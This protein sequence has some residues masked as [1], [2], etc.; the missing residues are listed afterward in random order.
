VTDAEPLSQQLRATT[1][2][3]HRDAERTPFMRVFFRAEL[4]RDA[5][6][7][8]L[9]RQ[10]FIYSA[11]EEEGEALRDDPVVG[12]MYAPE[13]LRGERLESDL[14][15]FSGATW[16]EQ[17]ES[18]PVTTRYMERIRQVAT[19]WPVGWVAHQWLRYMGNL[20][21]QEI[22]RRLVRQAYDVGEEGMAFHRYPDV[23]DPKAFL[24]EY[25][26][27]MDSMPLDEETKARVAEE[28]GRAFQLNI[29]LTEELAHDFDIKPPPGPASAEY[30]ALSQ[31]KAPS[32]SGGG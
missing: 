26:A 6:T 9:R 8:W 18:S 27:R 25:H 11:L 17:T 31:S 19:T 4:P 29:D 24:G 23:A 21:G 28:G 1:S 15:F 7:E 5:Y 10:W 2:V 20:G 3:I 32:G 16:R 13:L 12:R 14:D 22:L 30:E